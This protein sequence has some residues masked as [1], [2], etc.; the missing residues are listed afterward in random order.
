MFEMNPRSNSDGQKGEVRRKLSKLYSGVLHNK[1][2]NLGVDITELTEEELAIL[3]QV[4]R[5]E[6]LIA[7]VFEVWKEEHGTNPIIE[8]KHSDDSEVDTGARSS[9]ATARPVK[10]GDGDVPAVA[11]N[12][13]DG[14]DESDSDYDSGS[15]ARSP[16]EGSRDADSPPRIHRRQAGKN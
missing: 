14:S 1:T 4:K 6:H 13:A 15:S 12:K 7:A 11:G 9:Q 5:V 10:P 3:S 16:S 2:Q 8:T